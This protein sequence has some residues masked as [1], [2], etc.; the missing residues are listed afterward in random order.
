MSF[1]TNVKDFRFEC[2]DIGLYFGY[3]WHSA[4]IGLQTLRKY[5]CP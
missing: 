5:E 3:G 4:K 1:G 2:M